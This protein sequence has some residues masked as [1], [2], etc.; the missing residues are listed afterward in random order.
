MRVVALIRM[1]STEV[2]RIR[3]LQLS[4]NLTSSVKLLSHV[5]NAASDAWATWLGPV[6]R[7][8]QLTYG[9]LQGLTPSILIKSDIG[10]FRASPSIHHTNLK[11]IGVGHNIRPNLR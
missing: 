2:G 9:C 4:L 1:V 10:Y 8:P 7:P 5:C 6:Y 3:A 11:R